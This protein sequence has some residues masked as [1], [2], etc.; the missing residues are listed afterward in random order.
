MI[1]SS[2]HFDRGF[3]TP[4]AFTPSPAPHAAAKQ[5]RRRV[6]LSFTAEMHGAMV[7]ISIRRGYFDYFGD[8]AYKNKL[9]G[10]FPL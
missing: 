10:Q 5:P 6:T 3:A 7:P 2:R 4:P 8:Y 1:T 9:F